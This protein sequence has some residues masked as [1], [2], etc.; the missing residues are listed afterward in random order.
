MVTMTASSFA[1]SSGE[2]VKEEIARKYARVNCTGE[3]SS[4]LASY[5]SDVWKDTHE[6]IPLVWRGLIFCEVSHSRACQITHSAAHVR[7]LTLYQCFFAD[8]SWLFFV[9]FFLLTHLN[10]CSSKAKELGQLSFL[11][12]L[13]QAL[14]IFCSIKDLEMQSLCLHKGEVAYVR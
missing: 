13:F 1:G 6:C 14:G 8:L 2:W 9:L 5:M 7:S 4:Y 3:H 11:H 12:N 10:G